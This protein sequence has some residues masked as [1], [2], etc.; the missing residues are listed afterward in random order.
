MVK[1]PGYG[2]VS[3]IW[4]SFQ[5][6]IHIFPLTIINLYK[7]M[8]GG[9]IISNFVFGPLM[10]TK[11]WMVQIFKVFEMAPEIVSDDDSMEVWQ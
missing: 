10:Y 3:R 9:S 1:F 4:C 2:N 7:T 6:M 5:G 8:N 11:Q